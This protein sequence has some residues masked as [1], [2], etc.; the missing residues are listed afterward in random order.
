MLALLLV[1]AVVVAVVVASDVGVGD[2][3]VLLVSELFACV[4]VVVVIDVVFMRGS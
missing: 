3:D 1:V 4:V 2:V